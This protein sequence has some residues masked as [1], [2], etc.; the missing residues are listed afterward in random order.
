MRLCTPFA[1]RRGRQHSVALDGLTLHWV[2]ELIAFS[3]MF[4]LFLRSS[5]RSSGRVPPRSVST[6]W[7][8]GLGDSITLA[9]KRKLGPALSNFGGFLGEASGGDVFAL[10]GIAGHSSISITQR[11]VT[12]RQK[13]SAAYSQ[14]R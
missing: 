8:A 10:A 7:R 5:Q 6:G 2:A 12:L 3:I 4:G 13:L 1:D 14:R 11:Y 9:P